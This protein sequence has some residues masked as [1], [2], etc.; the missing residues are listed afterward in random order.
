[1][2]DNISVMFVSVSDGKVVIEDEEYASGE[3]FGEAKFSVH[4]VDFGK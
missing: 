1:M 3:L 4:V 2:S